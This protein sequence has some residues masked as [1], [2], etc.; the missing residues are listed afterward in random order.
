MECLGTGL[1]DL[2]K[3]LVGLGPGHCKTSLSLSRSP[4][5]DDLEEPTEGFRKLDSDHRVIVRPF[6]SHGRLDETRVYTQ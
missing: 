6:S 5:T 3:D 1:K 2:V 4:G